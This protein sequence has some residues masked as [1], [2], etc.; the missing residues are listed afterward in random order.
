MEH[1][2]STFFDESKTKRLTIRRLRDE[3]CSIS[4]DPVRI[5]TTISTGCVFIVSDLFFAGLNRLMWANL[6]AIDPK[7]LEM[8]GSSLFDSSYTI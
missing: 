3:S 5:R 8:L 1:H 4:I 6:N 2:E 7:S